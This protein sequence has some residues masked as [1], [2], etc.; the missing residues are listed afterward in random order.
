M[1]KSR[2][3]ASVALASLMA[4][5]ATAAFADGQY[6]NRIDYTGQGFENGELG[7]EI[8]GVGAESQ[9]PYLLWVLTTGP[10]ADVAD[11][12][13]PWGT[14]PMTGKGGNFKYVSSYYDLSE[15][16]NV[17]ATYEPD[18][19][20]E[21]Q[22]V[23]SHGCPSTIITGAPLTVDKT[24]RGKYKETWSWKI[25]KSVDRKYVELPSGSATFDYT[26]MVALDGDSVISHVKVLG[27]I[28][29]EN[30]NAGTT[31]T[32]VDV[33]D[34]LSN[35]VVCTIVGG[36]ANVSVV[37]GSPTVL[38]YYCSL[39]APNDS[40]ENTAKAMWPEQM[41]SATIKLEQGQ[42]VATVPVGAFFQKKIDAC[43]MVSDDLYG[44]LGQVCAGEAPKTFTYSMSFDA[45]E[46]WGECDTYTNT[47]SFVTNTT[48]TTGSDSQTVK[49]CKWN[50][51]LT[52]G[53]W[54][55]HLTSDRGTPNVAQYLP[56]S[57]G[58][59]VVD[60]TVKATAV[61]NTMNC[62]NAA[63]NSNNAIG[64]LAGHLLATE[65]NLK[66]NANTCIQGAVDAADAFLVARGYTGP[67]SYTLT[68][69]QRQQAISLKNPL[70]AYNNG[71]GCF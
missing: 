56:V 34:T 27:R 14:A 43:V 36:G 70:D 22:L 18:G 39:Q 58:N 21:T 71:G 38:Q 60:T 66:N 59:Y 40:L 64:C 63:T 42:D 69:A 6:D 3:W 68:A 20:G 50:D 7:T 11:I 4:L 19:P 31:A 37:A 33:S 29:L 15:L 45:P 52:P 55:T 61:W 41:L 17:Y 51:R 23:V 13:G 30:P 49:V 44:D 8:C 28:T 47:A 10:A 54:K 32:G 26:V 46:D 9:D 16:A 67:G 24:A 25:S 53:Y 12:T 2:L 1:K 5:S 62:G 57:L 48:G 65:L 35:D